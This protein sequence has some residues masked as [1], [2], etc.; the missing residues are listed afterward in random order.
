MTLFEAIR[1]FHEGQEMRWSMWGRSYKIS[2]AWGAE[3]PA[4]PD[5]I[6]SEEMFYEVTVVDLP[7]P[8]TLYDVLVEC[9]KFDRVAIDS[10]Q[11]SALA[12]GFDLKK[13][14]K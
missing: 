3:K 13:V 2:W 10:L 14:V 9:G 5:T 1:Q 7:R 11:R 4:F 12:A 8:V 6:A